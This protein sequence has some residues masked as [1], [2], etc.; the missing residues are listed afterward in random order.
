MAEKILFANLASSALAAN[1][2]SGGLSLTV[3]AATGVLFPNPGASEVFICK[4]VRLSDS[5]YEIIKVTAR[6]IDSFTITRGEDGTTPLNFV[7]GDKIVNVSSKGVYERFVQKKENSLIEGNISHQ[8]MMNYATASGTDTY[9]ATLS[10]AI[11]VYMAGAE[12]KIRFTNANTISAPTLNLNGLGAKTIKRPGG[13]ALDIGELKAGGE[14]T[15]RYDGADFIFNQAVYPPRYSSKNAIINGCCRVAQRAAPNLSNAY[16]YGQVDRFAAKADGTVGAG[17]ISQTTTAECGRTGYALHLAGVTLSAGGEAV[18][19]R[20][21]MESRDAKNFKNQTIIVHQKVWHDVGSAKN[22][23]ITINKA[24]AADNFSAV[25]SI[26][27]SGNQSVNNTTETT[28]SYSVAMGDCSNGVEIVVKGDCGAITTK[29][30]KFA[31]MQFEQGAVAT[32]FER[33]DYTVAEFKAMRYYEALADG[34]GNNRIWSPTETVGNGSATWFFKVRKRAIPTLAGTYHNTVDTA[35]P[36]HISL[37]SAA[38]N[39]SYFNGDCT[40]DAEL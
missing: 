29:N 3:T 6:S 31:E 33:V 25:T 38:G 11:T 7:T 10:P 1:L 19:H 22:F 34:N 5:A 4:I 36:D 30:F 14:Y 20:Y 17:T 12:Y 39:T 24:N 15:F 40:A 23:T 35:S 32:D 28:I 27:T 13:S 2:A 37:T 8:G 9:T 18:Y 26:G 16:Q 21:R